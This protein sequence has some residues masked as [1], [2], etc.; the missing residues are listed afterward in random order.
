MS[1]G[2]I[3][4]L[5]IITIIAF[6]RIIR[7]A[8]RAKHGLPDFGRGGRRGTSAE[9]ENQNSILARENEALRGKMGRL[10]ERLS[11][12]ERIA[13]DAPARLSA[14]IEKLR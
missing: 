2:M 9:L 13:T 14:E 1:S 10:E 4:T 6:S 5:A 7:T 3:F 12:L 8:I 11:V